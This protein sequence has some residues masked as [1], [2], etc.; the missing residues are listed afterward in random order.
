MKL[1]NQ[2]FIILLWV[3]TLAQTSPSYHTVKPKQTLYSISKE[4]N[5]SVQDIK[6]WNNLSSNEISINQKLIIGYSLGNVND[7][8]AENQSYHTI[9]PGE[10]LYSISK[11]YNVEVGEIKSWNKLQDNTLSVGQKLMVRHASSSG[12]VSQ[13]NPMPKTNKQTDSETDK[14]NRYASNHKVLPKETL[15]SISKKYNVKVED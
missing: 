5:V 1:I 10:T 12:V 8:A 11:K 9:Q 15:Y 7:Q 13:E 3:N 2:I 14:I 4:Y 6:R